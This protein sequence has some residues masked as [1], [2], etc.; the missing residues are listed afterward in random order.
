[1]LSHSDKGTTNILYFF[2]SHFYIFS[3]QNLVSVKMLIIMEDF[4]FLTCFQDIDVIEINHNYTFTTMW[5]AD[6]NAF[7]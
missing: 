2:M 6:K 4:A 1:M 5:G 3:S 7:S